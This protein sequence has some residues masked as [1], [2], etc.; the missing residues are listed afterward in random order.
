MNYKKYMFNFINRGPCLNKL[1]NRYG[2][3]NKCWYFINGRNI[4]VNK[5]YEK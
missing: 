1:C 4:Y 2:S 5:I 3:F